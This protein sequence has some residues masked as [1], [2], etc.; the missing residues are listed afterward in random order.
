M[1]HLPLK[2]RYQYSVRY[3]IPASK[4]EKFCIEKVNRIVSFTLQFFCKI[5]SIVIPGDI[6]I[7]M[8]FAINK[9]NFRG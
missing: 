9:K 3:Q 5:D 4:G 1:V 7:G 8:H 6:R 2:D